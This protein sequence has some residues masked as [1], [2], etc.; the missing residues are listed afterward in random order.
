MADDEQPKIF[1]DEDWK[2]QVQREKELARQQAEQAQQQAEAAGPAAGGLPP[3]VTP[4]GGGPAAAAPG[5]GMP[6]AAGA[7]PAPEGAPEGGDPREEDPWRLL[8]SG[9]VTQTMLALGAIVPRGEKQVMV[10]LDYAV[11]NLSLLEA[12]REKTQGNL[13]AEEEGELTQALG[14]LQRLYQMRAQQMHEQ[15]LRQAGVNDPND[16]RQ[17]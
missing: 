7:A 4:L 3:N 6:T 12:L 2:A 16:L 10:D 11:Y 17:Q 1:V 9:L 14:E 8:V 13:T 15:T 5:P